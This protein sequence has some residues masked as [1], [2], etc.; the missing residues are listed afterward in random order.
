MNSENM[1][2][3]L[4]EASKQI[5]GLIAEKEATIIRDMSDSFVQQAAEDEDKK[6]K[7][8]FGVTVTIAPVNNGI[9]VKTALKNKVSR[10]AVAE[11]VVGE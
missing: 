7:Y 9:L 11:A 8:S 6:L 1:K 3:A 4:T 5:A 2:D 10:N